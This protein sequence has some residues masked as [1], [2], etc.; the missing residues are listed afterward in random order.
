LG[1]AGA[2]G[3]CAGDGVTE[4]FL[5][6]GVGQG[7]ELQVYVLFEGAD[8]GITNEK[9]VSFE[10]V[11]HRSFSGKYGIC[12]RNSWGS[13]IQVMLAGNGAFATN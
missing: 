12:D 4:D 8:T 9:G 3:F 6:T 11:K 2:F 5:A 1:E 10:R 13:D 7:I